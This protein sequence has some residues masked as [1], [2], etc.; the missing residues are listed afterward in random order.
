MGLSQDVGSE[1][2]CW[3]GREASCSSIAAKPFPDVRAANIP[4]GVLI[5][6]TVTGSILYYK[7]PAEIADQA[8][9]SGEGGM[10]TVPHL[11]VTTFTNHMLAPILYTS[12]VSASVLLFPMRASCWVFAQ[13]YLCSTCANLGFLTRVQLLLRLQGMGH[14]I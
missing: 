13:R 11:S 3:H 8:I 14:E 2:G 7:D 5:R 6:D 4:F 1:P 12:Q 9:S 10:W